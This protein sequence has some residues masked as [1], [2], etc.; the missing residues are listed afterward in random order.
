MT[1]ALAEF[2]YSYVMTGILCFVI[3]KYSVCWIWSK[4]FWTLHADEYSWI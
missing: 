3:T 1:I 4:F 2:L